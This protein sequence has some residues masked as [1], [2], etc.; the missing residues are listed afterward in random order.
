MAVTHDTDHEIAPRGARAP[1]AGLCQRCGTE[2]PYPHRGQRFCS[3]ACRAASSRQGK[4]DAL[5]RTL[6][7]LRGQIDTALQA[8]GAYDA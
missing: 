6:I 1:L 2:I 3:G 7:T 8:L 5:R 4:T